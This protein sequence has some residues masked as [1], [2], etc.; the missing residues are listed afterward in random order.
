MIPYSVLF[1]TPTDALPT[2]SALGSSSYP[3]TGSFPA[4][5]RQQ[6][7]YFLAGAP[8]IAY[9]TQVHVDLHDEASGVGP[10]VL[11]GSRS[12]GDEV[13]HRTSTNERTETVEE[14]LGD[15]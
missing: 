5:S 9:L 15:S 1:H 7:I 4:D 8:L 2:L 3:G 12:G 13:H 6:R 10:S 14:E 11:S